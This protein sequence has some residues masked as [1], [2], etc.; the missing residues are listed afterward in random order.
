MLTSLQ[1]HYCAVGVVP[2]LKGEARAEYQGQLKYWHSPEHYLSV[3]WRLSE[4]TARRLWA[5]EQQVRG[6]TVIGELVS[7]IYLL[8][9]QGFQEALVEGPELVRWVLAKRKLLGGEV[10]F[11]VG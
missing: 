7:S 6:F 11:W 5:T 3:P 10:G 2:A 9:Q 4:P 1:A 8:G